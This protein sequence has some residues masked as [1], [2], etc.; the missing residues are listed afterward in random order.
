[1]LLSGVAVAHGD[2]RGAP[3]DQHGGA[4]QQLGHE[5]NAR[6]HMTHVWI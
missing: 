6:A 4:G 3:R 1:M 5:A 2:A